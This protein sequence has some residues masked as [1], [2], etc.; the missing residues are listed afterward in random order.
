MR[1]A[2]NHFFLLLSFAATLFT[3]AKAWAPTGSCPECKLSVPTCRSK[4]DCSPWQTCLQGQCQ[5]MTCD[6]A[7][8]NCPSD[9]P[10]VEVHCVWSP[11]LKRNQCVGSPVN[12]QGCMTDSNCAADQFCNPQNHC[13]CQDDDNLC[14]TDKAQCRKIRIAA[15]TIEDLPTRCPGRQECNDNCACAC[16]PI[17][18]GPPRESPMTGAEI[19]ATPCAVDA[20]CANAPEGRFCDPLNC[21][22]V[23][24]LKDGDCDDGNACTSD[25]CSLGQCTHVKIDHCRHG[26]SRWALPPTER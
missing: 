25:L 13:T 7:A 24:C 15:P 5:G 4:L 6:L 8:D 20:D 9:D 12:P 10:C 11:T 18:K 17:E 23:A 26:R 2:R 1:G 3:S 21:Q 22:C 16:P 19:A 14:F